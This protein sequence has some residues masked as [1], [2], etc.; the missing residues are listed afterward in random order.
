MIS[1]WNELQKRKPFN[2]WKLA[3]SIK[4]G[5]NSNIQNQEL[6]EYINIVY[7]FYSNTIYHASIS[8]SYY[9]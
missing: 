2:L 8:S 4:K 1:E 3:F 9:H 7:I 6:H 5:R